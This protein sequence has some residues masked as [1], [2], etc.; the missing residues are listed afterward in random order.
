MVPSSE[1]DGNTDPQSPSAHETD[2]E[3]GTEEGMCQFTVQGVTEQEM[4][5]FNTS[6]YNLA[7][8]RHLEQKGKMLAVGHRKA[9]ESIYHN[10]Q[11]YPKMFPWLFPYGLGGIGCLRGVKGLGLVPSPTMSEGS[12]IRHLLAN[13]DK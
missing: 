3:S 10:P 12:H 7:A 9:P 13:H 2:K 11:L 6:Q 4:L 1:E 5:T 8:L